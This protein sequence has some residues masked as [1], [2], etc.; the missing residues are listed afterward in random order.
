M[1]RLSK[2]WPPA[3]I[4]QEARFVVVIETTRDARRDKVG[5]LMLIDADGTSG[6]SSR[7]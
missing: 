5:V 2:T 6:L 1:A 4:E 3:V 7:R